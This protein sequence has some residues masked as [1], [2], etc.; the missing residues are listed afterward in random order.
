MVG[1]VGIAL[2][3][4]LEVTANPTNVPDLM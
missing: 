4:S 2:T 1:T 3:R